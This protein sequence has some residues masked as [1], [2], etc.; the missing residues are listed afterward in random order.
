MGWANGTHWGQER[1][2]WDLVGILKTK[3]QPGNVGLKERMMLINLGLQEVGLG[4][5]D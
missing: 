2:I 3:R 4:G 5:M 1:S